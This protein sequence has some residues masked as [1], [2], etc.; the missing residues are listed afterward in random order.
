MKKFNLAVLI[1]VLAAGCSSAALAESKPISFV[2]ASVSSG[3][4]GELAGI[5]A[6]AAACGDVDGD[7]DLDLYVGNFSD[8]PPERYIGAGGPVPNK[9]LINENG[10]FVD[11]G[12]QA[13]V[14]KA[15]TSG[16][17]FVDLDND[18][19]LDLYVSN[20]RR[21][22]TVENRLYENVG[23]Q[24]RDVSEGNEACIIMGGRSIG[25]L[26]YDGDGLLD[27]LVCGDR[28]TG[29]GRTILFRNKGKLL[30][31]DVTAQVGLPEYLPGLGIVT[32]DFNEDGRPDIFISEANRLFLST[33]DGKYREAALAREVFGY[34]LPEGKI[35]VVPN[36]AD[37]EQFSPKN[38]HEVKAKELKEKLETFASAQDSK[39]AGEVR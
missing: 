4:H 22:L 34:K 21:R 12:Q 36:G 14:F 38:E 18:G 19:D 29:G 8:R 31:E 13:V 30:F 20:N 27:L 7:G 15:R 11:S 39:A 10:K 17:V 32:P 28:W 35:T 24:L 23:G 5:M 6:H 3:I 2:D 9:L 26:D 33:G 16:A 25:V 1:V 37:I